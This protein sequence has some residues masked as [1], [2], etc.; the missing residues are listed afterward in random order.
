V[1]LPTVPGDDT[2]IVFGSFAEQK[3]L[4]VK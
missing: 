3:R 1:T 2:F 4:K